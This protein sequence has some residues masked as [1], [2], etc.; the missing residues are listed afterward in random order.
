MIKIKNTNL[1]ISKES[2]L[3][4]KIEHAFQ[5][6]YYPRQ[7]PKGVDVEKVETQASESKLLMYASIYIQ[8]GV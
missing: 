1:F 8:M 2:G 6:S 5:V 7:V 4:L 3:R